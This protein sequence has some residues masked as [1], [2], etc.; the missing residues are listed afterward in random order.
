MLHE[1]SIRNFATVESLQIEFNPGMSV[2]T[3]ETGAG[4]SVIL[5]ALSLTLGDRADKGAVRAGAAK[6]DLSAEFNIATIASAKLWLEEHDLDHD[7]S[8]TCILRRVIT[9]DGRSKGYINGSPATMTSLR[10][11]GEML[12]DI[13][14]QHE[15]QSLLNKATHL[16]LLDDFS[17]DADLRLK[18]QSTWKQWQTNY[19]QMQQLR[20]ATEES[21]AQIQLL[22][23]QLNELDEI[24]IGEN[25]VE[26]LEAEFKI[27]NSADSTLSAV[28]KALNYCSDDGESDAISAIGASVSALKTQAAHD[29]KL[30]SIVTLLQGA[31]IQLMEAVSDLRGFLDGFND[32]PQR[33]EDINTR[34]SLLHSVARKHKIKPNEL[35]ALVADLRGQLDRFENSDA[36]VAKLIAN[37]ALL[38][39]QY[40]KIAKQVSASRSKGAEKLA[41][42]VNS[43]LAM[44]GM[45][46]ASLQIPLSSNSSDKPSQ[47]GLESAEFLV[48]TNPGQKAGPLN[49]IASGGELSRISLAIQV[50]T[51]QTS[52]TPILVFDEVDV[53]IGG[54]VAKVVGE[55]LRQLAERT[56]IFCVTHQAQVASQGHNHFYVSKSSGKDSTLTKI[57]A[58]AGDAKVKEIARMLGGDD[59]TQESIAHAQQMVALK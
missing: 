37:D 2:I 46:N 9:S 7:E 4:K 14:S 57:V 33:L 58:I 44:L 17:V 18:L 20:S 28:Q 42:A 11:L 12:I 25:E 55:L 22:S 6:A 24:E 53:G 47:H 40:L 52:A 39:D 13:H 54:G 41:K 38:K 27:L 16:R 10:E 43:Q 15:H 29:E 19:Q 48:S 51:A 34:L 49:K 1:L 26:E 8:D 32:D 36:E 35:P 31:E 30:A 59:Y 45:Q 3:G 56:Q 21:S 23:Y 5:G 50:I